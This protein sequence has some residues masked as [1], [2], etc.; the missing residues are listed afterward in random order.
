MGHFL[1][2]FAQ[3]KEAACGG[4]PVIDE[5]IHKQAGKLPTSGFAQLARRAAT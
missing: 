3:G 1:L 4:R 5:A 2:V